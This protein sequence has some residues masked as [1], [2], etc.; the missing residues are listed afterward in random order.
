MA[1]S[2]TSPTSNSS[3]EI[4]EV[5]IIEHGFE[6]PPGPETPP[7]EGESTSGIIFITDVTPLDGKYVGEKFY[8][9]GTVPESIVLNSITTNSFRLRVKVVLIGG[10]DAYTPTG[11]VNDVLVTNLVESSTKRYYYG[12]AEIEL[13]PEDLTIKARINNNHPTIVSIIRKSDLGP[14]IYDIYFGTY[15]GNQS[16]LKEGD[17][18]EIHCICSPD[19][20]SVK[21]LD[22]PAISCSALIVG[23]I[24]SGGEGRRRA[25]GFATVKNVNGLYEVEAQ[26]YNASGIP[27]EVQVSGSELKLSQLKPS[28]TVFEIDYHNLYGAVNQYDEVDIVVDGEDFDKVIYAS[29]VLQIDSPRHYNPRKR[30]L[31]IGEVSGTLSVTLIRQANNAITVQDIPV[32]I[33]SADLSARVIIDTE[34]PGVL[35]KTPEGKRYQ[36]TV[37]PNQ[38][39]LTSPK[40]S[41]N[42][43]ENVN[44]V[45][46]ESLGTYSGF[47]TLYESL[48]F[49]TL[50]IT[51]ALLTS[52]TSDTS[53]NVIL[54]DTY[55]IISESAG[56]LFIS[57]GQSI[58]DIPFDID[59]DYN[60]LMFGTYKLK[61]IDTDEYQSFGY[62]ILDDQNNPATYGN[63]I[64]LLD[65]ALIRS[66]TLGLLTVTVTRE[67]VINV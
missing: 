6:G 45:H 62:C 30:A 17:Q 13:D 15:P 61:L 7:R 67:E 27:G 42:V 26:G 57:P 21:V 33:A 14:I 18:V 5:E 12:E 4:P 36:V 55:R 29:Q 48:S 9:S 1:P 37:I 64:K 63:K 66:N 59:E 34:V 28:F 49:N 3:S 39:L 60:V 8:K 10:F 19:T 38:A 32:I 65:P 24:N 22:S 44:L 54:E 52:V 20:D 16:E 56:K 53:T 58:I 50:E 41:F 25:S 51:D 35:V 43:Q 31:A 47:I 46:N 11:Y 40:L 23:E 2:V